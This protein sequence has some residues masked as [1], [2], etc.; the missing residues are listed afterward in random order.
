[1][2]VTFQYPIFDC[3]ALFKLKESVGNK[4]I[5]NSRYKL[6]PQ[7]ESIGFLKNTGSLVKGNKKDTKKPTIQTNY[8]RARKAMVLSIPSDYSF[9]CNGIKITPQVE[10]RLFVPV[11]DF[12]SYYQIKLFDQLNAPLKKNQASILK[13]AIASYRK[14]ALTIPTN[15]EEKRKSILQDPQSN[16]TKLFFH[17]TTPQS[18]ARVI[19]NIVRGNANKCE[20]Q[21][22]DSC[23]IKHIKS[24]MPITIFEINCPN[25]I[26][27]F[28]EEVCFFKDKGIRVYTKEIKDRISIW[29]I[30]KIDIKSDID[31]TQEIRQYILATHRFNQSRIKLNQFVEKNDG[32]LYNEEVRNKISKLITSKLTDDR[33]FNATNAYDEQQASIRNA[34]LFAKE[35]ETDK[36]ETIIAEI[37]NSYSGNKMFYSLL[38]KDFYINKLKELKYSNLLVNHVV[39]IESVVNSLTKGDYQ[40][41]MK[42]TKTHKEFIE[43]ACSLLK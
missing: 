3:R 26:S 8:Y 19:S 39:W 31:F 4:T 23:I 40:S 20:Y 5:G 1:M 10:S 17:S 12:E 32:V 42:L 37:N 35:K 43:A 2:F 16:L 33:F 28:G 9:N 7:D 34:I 30:A 38:K 24:G 29:L 18:Y 21:T 36:L 25:G 41:F 14:L 11:K 27:D 15:Y 22:V 6:S 13:S